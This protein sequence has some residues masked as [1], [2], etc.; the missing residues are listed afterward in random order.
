MIA[1]GQMEYTVGE[2]K[3]FWVQVTRALGHYGSS[4]DD[5]VVGQVDSFFGLNTLS[6][7][8]K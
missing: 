5:N 1:G 8:K 2:G 6:E 3:I 4:G 7:K